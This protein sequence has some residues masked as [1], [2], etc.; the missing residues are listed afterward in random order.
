MHNYWI[1]QTLADFNTGKQKQALSL[2]VGV[3]GR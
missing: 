1:F 2:V 3:D